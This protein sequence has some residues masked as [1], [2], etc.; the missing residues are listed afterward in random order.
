MS[1]GTPAADRAYEHVK[2]QLLDGT[3]AG[4]ALLSEGAVAAELGVS[5]TPV[6][7]AF[8]R[9]QSEGFLRLYPK[10][11]ALVVPVSLSAG[12]EIMETRLLLE[13]YAL[14]TVTARGEEALKEL[15]GELAAADAGPPSAGGG[16]VEAARDFHSRL[17]SAAGNSVVG[18]IYAS[19]W[20]QQRRLAE[21]SL[22]GPEH[23]AEDI[24]EHHRIARALQEGDAHTAR[25]LLQEHIS[26]I[27]RRLGLSST[28]LRLPAPPS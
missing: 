12:R 3:Y 17:L 19:L 6:R 28:D 26:G 4:G 15:G 9:L 2:T 16:T 11:G 13:T 21:A 10:R 22:T 27:L 24:E 1:R 18:G 5:R 8:L 20:D 7:E 25:A 14:D 23:A